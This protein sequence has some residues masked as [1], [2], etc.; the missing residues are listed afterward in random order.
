M[1]FGIWHSGNPLLCPISSVVV[2]CWALAP[3][4]VWF[5]VQIWLGDLRVVM[6]VVWL[7]LFDLFM[8]CLATL[9]NWPA[10]HFPILLVSLVL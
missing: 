1:F 5:A 8:I 4:L 9:L 7:F 3:L 10:V 2:A 6:V